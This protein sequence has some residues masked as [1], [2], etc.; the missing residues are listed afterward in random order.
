MRYVPV[1]FLLL[2]CAM[3]AGPPVTFTFNVGSPCAG[4]CRPGG[5]YVRAV[6]ID[7]AGYTYLTGNVSVKIPTTPNAFQGTMTTSSCVGGPSGLDLCNDAFVMKLDPYGNIVWATYLGG[8]GDDYG[9][10]I[11]VDSSGNIFVAGASFPNVGAMQGSGAINSFPITSGAAFSPPASNVGAP[12]VTKLSADGS[13]LIYSTF[14]PGGVYSSV[15]VPMAIDSSGNAYVAYQSNPNVPVPTTPGAF[16]AAPLNH[17]GPGVVVKVNASGSALIYATYLSGSGPNG[18]QEYPLSIAVDTSG[19]AVI[20]GYT[21]ATNFPLTPNAFDSTNPNDGAIGFLSKLN[22]GGTALIYS[23]YFGN[24][25]NVVKLDS[26]G[27][28]YVLAQAV[29]QSFPVTTGPVPS[30]VDSAAVTHLSADGSSLVWSMFV[31]GAASIDLDHVGNIYAAGTNPNAAAT[32]FVERLV[33]GGVLSGMETLGGPAVEAPGNANPVYD[34]AS[35][36]S[37]APNG[38]VVL[39][40]TTMSGAFPGISE[41]VTEFGFEYVT[42]FFINATVM[43]AANYTAGIVAPGEIVTI[44]GYGFGQDIGEVTKAPNGLLPTEYSLVASVMFDEFYAPLIYIQ[45]RQINA[46]V[47]WAITGRSSVHMSITVGLGGSF[48]VPETFGPYTIAVAPSVPGVFYVTNSDGSINSPANP[49]A[50]GDFVTLYGTGGGS[51]SSAGITGGLWSSTPLVSLTLPVTITLGGENAGLIYAG[52]APTLL[53]GFF[54][55]NVRVPQDLPPSGSTPMVVNIGSGQ[56]TVPVAI[57]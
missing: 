53:S 49:A 3:V 28:A 40:G 48:G 23:T 11:A 18:A 55:V 17:G 50:H 37:V 10:A 2:R 51:T 8:N 31:P 9:T 47:P 36:I 22:S 7:A 39:S 25:A 1:L 42:S 26:N 46:Q 52:S 32:V 27:D 16:Q 13:R 19:N 56:T 20:G 33:P 24:S 54:Q 34:S 38:S 57:R 14:L 29:V 12:F 21:R 44:L 35:L 30:S 6:T 45:S 4:N 15:V 41:P 5:I 43:N